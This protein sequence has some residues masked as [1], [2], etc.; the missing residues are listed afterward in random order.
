M[1]QNWRDLLFCHWAIEPE[2]I[3]A[4]LPQGL[5]VDLYD[6]K[7]WIGVVPFFMR[8][9]RPFFA[10]ALP[11]IS[12][13][14][15]LNVRTYVHDDAGFPGVW[16]YSLDCNQ[17]LAVWIARTLF[18]LNYR[19]AFMRA[20][21]A[22]A[23]TRYRSRLAGEAW[24][25]YFRYAPRTPPRHAEPDSIEFFLVE[26]YLLFT[27]DKN[28]QIW[29]GRVHHAPYQISDAFWELSDPVIPRLTGFL[30]LDR[31]PDHV[32]HSPGADVSI[33]RLRRHVFGGEIS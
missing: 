24:E 7:A 22:N 20:E 32:C 17:P 15:E 33:F 25:A 5:H 8:D 6:K 26:R 30:G 27:A 19:H 31:P 12:N 28:R 1:R 13:F 10:P 14:L 16:F 11:V 29:S 23:F 21:Q 4:T 2:Q 3:R 9:V 18:H